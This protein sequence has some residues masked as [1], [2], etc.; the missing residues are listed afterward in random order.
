MKKKIIWTIVAVLIVGLLAFKDYYWGYYA[1]TK[2]D[3]KIIC[4]KTDWFL[5]KPW[6]WIKQ[7]VTQILWLDEAAP[8]SEDRNYYIAT[9]YYK[10]LGGELIHTIDVID[11]KNNRFAGIEKQDIQNLFPDTLD[12]LDYIKADGCMTDLILHLKNQDKNDGDN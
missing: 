7:P 1:L 3:L 6:T 11:I 2:S 12:K 8:I 4:T 5:L 9:V 10:R